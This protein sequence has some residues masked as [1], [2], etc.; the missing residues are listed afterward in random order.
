MAG[1]GISGCP[2]TWAFDRLAGACRP[3]ARAAILSALTVIL[4]ASGVRLEAAFKISIALAIPGAV[5]ALRDGLRTG[6]D[7]SHW[8][9]L[10]TLVIAMLL[11][12]L[13]KW[14]GPP[15]F[16][17]FQANYADQFNYLSMAWT[18]TRYDYPTIRNMD[19]DTE[20]A[21][22]VGGIA[23]MIAFRPGVPLMLGGSQPRLI[24]RY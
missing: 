6:W 22:G 12:L 9:F 8:A 17:V 21:I 19:F 5:L 20:I 4:Y 14:L 7:Y 24:S 15:E 18:P 1:A 11:V 23:T 10:V 16:S 13:P 2:R 3:A